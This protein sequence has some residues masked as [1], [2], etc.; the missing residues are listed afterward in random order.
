MRRH[1]WEEFLNYSKWC[2]ES[3][4]SYLEI[5]VQCHSEVGEQS[6]RNQ[7][8]G[9][10]SVVKKFLDTSVINWWWN[11]HHS[12]TQNSMYSRILCCVSERFFNIPNPTKLGKTELQESDPRKATEIMLLS[13]E[14][15]LNSSGTFSQDSQW[16]SEQ[17]GT[18][19]RNFQ[20]KNSIHVNV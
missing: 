19:T 14:N 3:W 9:Q 15:R 4:K 18:N 8:P 6:G 5:D 11:S 10:N 17:F 7:L 20:R 1:L 13:T 12:S 16:S 2:Q